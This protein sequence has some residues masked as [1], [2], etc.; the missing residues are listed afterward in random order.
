MSPDQLELVRLS[1]A[2]AAPRADELTTTFYRRLFTT[3][4]AARALFPDD[5]ADQRRKLALALS[6]I[7]EATARPDELVPYLERLGRR[8]VGYG[9]VAEHY[10]VVADT[11]RSTLAEVLGP[12]WSPSLDEAWR[13]ALQL[14]SDV[15]LQGAAAGAEAGAAA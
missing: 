3:A 2:A 9:A 6:T 10:P 12:A 15:M 13:A 8:H 11:L 14:V 1:F 7:V 4:P 5:L